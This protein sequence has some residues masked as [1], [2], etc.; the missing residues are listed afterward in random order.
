MRYK[1]FLL[2][3]SLWTTIVSYGQIVVW[4][5]DQDPIPSNE[6]PIGKT[7]GNLEV[8]LVGA[9]IY[10]V[11][12]QVP[13]GVNGVEPK[14]SLVYNSKSTNGNV[15]LGW[16]ISGISTITRVPS[17]VFHDG[18]VSAV[19]FSSSDRFALDGQRL[20]LKS[21]TYGGDGAEYQTE[22][23]SNIKIT[24]H[25]VSPYGANYGPKYFK[26]QYPDGSSATYGNSN[27]S[28]SKLA[29][30]IDRWSNSSGVNLAYTYEENGG[31]LFISSIKYVSTLDALVV[32]PGISLPR[33]QS[34]NNQLPFF[35]LYENEVKFYYNPK[36]SSKE[37]F[38]IGG[39]KFSNEQ[40][41]SKVE[42]RSGGKVFRSYALDYKT[43]ALGYEQLAKIKEYN[44]IDAK[45]LTPLEFKYNNTVEQIFHTTRNQLVTNSNLSGDATLKTHAIL[46][47]DFDGD[48]DLDYILYNKK[49]AEYWVFNTSYADQKTGIYKQVSQ[50]GEF[51]T[52]LRFANINQNNEMQPYD[53]WVTILGSR[54]FT[55][56]KIV[57]NVIVEDYSKIFTFPGLDTHI[58]S[59]VPFICGGD[60][61]EADKDYFAA[62]FRGNGKMDILGIEKYKEG[63]VDICDY[64]DQKVRSYTIYSEQDAYF[65]NMDRNDTSPM[66]NL[67]YVDNKDAIATFAHDFTG[68]GRADVVVVKP[69]KILLYSLNLNQNR[70]ELIYTHTEG[71]INKD[72]QAHVGDFNGDGKLDLLIVSPS[73]TDIFF[74][75]GSSLVKKQ[76]SSLYYDPKGSSSDHTSTPLSSDLRNFKTIICDDVNND[77]KT[78]II[79]VSSNVKV[80]KTANSGYGGTIVGISVLRNLGAGEF[81]LSPSQ[82]NSYWA[83][84]STYDWFSTTGN[85]TFFPIPYNLTPDKK[86]AFV[87]NNYRLGFFISGGTIEFQFS[88]DNNK[89]SLL[90]EI[91]MDGQTTSIA[92]GQYGIPQEN[93]DFSHFQKYET[94]K[95]TYPLYEPNF[96]SNISVVSKIKVTDGV[97]SLFKSFS[98]A[99]PIFNLQG[100]G[101]LGFK[102]LV[103][104]NW[105]DK[106]ENMFK[107]IKEFDVINRGLLKKETVAAGN[108]WD[109]FIPPSSPIARLQSFESTVNYEYQTEFL[110]NKV[111]KP[112]L[113]KLT[114]KNYGGF[115]AML[116][117]NY[118]EKETI[119]TYNQYNDVIKQQIQYKEMYGLVMVGQPSFTL[120]KTEIIENTYAYG[121]TNPSYFMSRLL[122]SKK[123]ET[124]AGESSFTTEDSYTYDEKG[125]VVE[126]LKKGNNTTETRTEKNTYDQYG[127]IV[128]KSLKAG[129]LPERK[130]TYK[131]GYYGRFLTEGTDVEGLK[132]T[133]SYNG[134]RGLLRE[135]KNAFGHITKYTYNNWGEPLSVTDYLGKVTQTQ[136]VKTDRGFEVITTND[137]GSWNRNTFNAK[138]N[139]IQTATKDLQGQTVSRSYEY[140]AYNRVVKESEGYFGNTPSL[141]NET[142]YDKKGRVIKVKTSKG[143]EITKTYTLATIKEND[144]VMTKETKVNS[145]GQTITQK[146]E[147]G[148]IKYTYF[149]NGNLKSANYEGVVV[150]QEQDGWGR[151]IKLMDPAAGV[152]TYAYNAYGESIK[153]VSPKGTTV[154]TLDNFGKLMHK[155]ITG[156]HTNTDINYTYDNESKQLT[157]FVADVSGTNYTYNY[158]YDTYHRLIKTTEIT[159]LARFSK[160]VAF[161]DFGRALE[162]TFGVQTHGKT[163]EKKIKHQYKNGYHWQTVD[164][165]TNQ[166]LTSKVQVNAYGQLT[167]SNLGNGLEVTN[168]YDSY[169][170]LQTNKVKK[171][172]AEL[173][174][175]ANQF[176]AATSNLLSRTNGLFNR[177]EIFT[178]DNLDRL[179]SF[180]NKVG[181]QET[182]EYDGKGRIESN[183]IGTYG[184]PSETSY[185]LESIELNTIAQP[186][187]QLRPEQQIA[188][189]AFKKP[190]WIKESEKENIYF[191]YNPDNKRSVMHYGNLATSKE[192]SSLKRYYST[193]GNIEVNYNKTTNKVDFVFYLD[194]DAYSATVIA[195]GENTPEY[196]Y[197]HRDYLGSILAITN[198]VGTIVEKRHFDAWGNLVFVKDGQNNDLSQLTFMD[199]G[200]TGH[201]H[202]EK[203]ALI[204]MNGR[205]YDPMLRRFLAPDNFIQDLSNTQN[206]NRYGYVLNNPLTYVDESGEI[207]GLVFGLR[208]L[209]RQSKNGEIKNLWD[210]VK[211]FGSGYIAGTIAGPNVMMMEG[212]FAGVGVIVGAFTGLGTGDWSSFKNAIRIGEGSYYLDSN[213]SFFK[214]TWQGISRF[215]FELPQTTAGHAYLQLKNM[216]YEVD[217]V[218]YFGGATFAIKEYAN[219]NWGISLGNFISVNITD[220]VQGPFNEYILTNP[221]LL[222]EYGHTFDSSK[223]GL[224][225][226]VSI[227]IP[228][229]K[230]DRETWTEIRA[231]NF[232]A[233]YLKKYYN[234]DWKEKN[235]HLETDRHNAYPL[236]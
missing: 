64:Y 56:N 128:E 168:V 93:L 177:G 102:G 30:A 134:T 185:Q 29:F 71:T 75:T 165:L 156:D 27:N 7:E 23:Y 63:Y 142:V 37:E 39:Q 234:L 129:N 4:P 54:V 82:T 20:L 224:S 73:S 38:Y 223:H 174:T 112:R 115:S 192:Q 3:C 200:Y 235:F 158:E 191:D 219:K 17:T 195:K 222:H 90:K 161:D 50:S 199:R 221:L 85:E 202:L 173:F 22:N 117:R 119:N 97:H 79:Q 1:N 113:T 11:P 57:N 101:F 140:D 226:L 106:P 190:V 183:N 148:E 186:H 197:L 167:K 150:S 217:R 42:S 35:Q 180:T 44:G 193:D 164:A 205:L 76:I 65:L 194:G 122:K 25:G 178:Y 108:Q 207:F 123:I 209:I 72:S 18:K 201:E 166:V 104:T 95:E 203:V 187:Y 88:H 84:H 94:R 107:N 232:A 78:D 59:D 118:F 61:Q 179:T 214:Q 206:F 105:Y 208:N 176:N 83:P 153:E 5:G 74:S 109:S 189:N 77:G 171:G 198:N 58:E 41:L 96:L 60:F 196:Y 36:S 48:G 40:Y 13:K 170:Y 144:G 49:K 19:D 133:Y 175:L 227:G 100:I 87:K 99:S 120:N 149:S 6:T 147:G 172:T 26:V 204:Q 229:M 145:L 33:T 139:K 136:Y 51:D 216:N 236:E 121:A 215:T 218:E 62:D 66:I 70:I 116:G 160:A 220:K 12:I 157:S 110:S 131:Y 228:S 184:Y 211:A 21:G 135:K 86:F 230:G 91:K 103:S 233:K 24:S 137:E 152:Y 15:G 125:R 210:G 114:E 188:Y 127:N 68:D 151:K 130:Q 67:G 2:L 28:R 169:G 143:K 212:G 124:A 81:Q 231:N 181:V 132:T 155:K 159:P 126:V 52:L 111:F 47:G 14:V 154:F 69:E 163:V 146:D 89:D 16:S 43:N 32:D 34:L 9:A 45:T 98:Y 46:T 138:G 141:W 31:I 225:Y 182:Q 10:S 8:N 80:S 92:Y 162:E 213:R 55:V 53:S